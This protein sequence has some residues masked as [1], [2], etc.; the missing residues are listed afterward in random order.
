MLA[1][2]MTETGRAL[3]TIETITDIAAIEGADSIV[4]AR[5]RGWD[6][7][8]GKTQ[9]EVGDTVI[10]VEVDSLLPISDPRFAF[11]ASRGV[12]NQNGVEGHVLKTARL[13]GQ[14]S[15][16]IAFD[17]SDFP[18]VTDAQVGDDVTDALAIIKWDPPLPAELISNARGWLPSWVSASS[19]IRVQNS[20]DILAA[21]AERGDWLAT[22]KID[23]MSM[24]VWSDGDD[25][26]VAGRNVDFLE[27]SNNMFWQTANSLGLHPSI[28]SEWGDR[29]VAI[30]GELFGPGVIKNSLAVNDVEFRAFTLYVDGIEVPRIQWPNWLLDIA[31]PVYDFD[32]PHSVDEAVKQVDGLKSLIN[33]QRR[34]EGVVWRN[35]TRAYVGLPNGRSVRASLKVISPAYLMKADR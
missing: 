16:G 2:K 12:R 29:R 26:G 8:V 34:A 13:R 22:E 30:Q 35:R 3:A 10:Y 5:I 24:T 17:P 32:L 18:E 1:E 25:Y 11:L 9:F 4:R 21:D 15:Q 7:V 14:Y 6:V 33:P 31:T 19:E 23:G 28:G 20:S 27:A